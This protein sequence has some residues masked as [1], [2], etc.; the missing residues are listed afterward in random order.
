MR[1][2]AIGLF[3]SLVIR[4]LGAT[5]RIRTR[6]GENL[7][8]ARRMSSQLVFVFWHGR[9]L[10]M[11]YTHRN[12]GV[13]ILASEHPDG[14]MLG[15]TIRFLGF[16]HVR[17]SS[18]RGGARAI[19]AM[20]DRLRAGDDIGLT[21][22]GPRGPMHVVKPGAAE[23]AKLSGCA[24]IPVT[25]ASRR[26]RTFASWDRFELPLP[27]TRVVVRY[28][29]PVRVPSDASSA[30]LETARAEVERILNDITRAADNDVR[31]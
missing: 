19:L 11:A 25:S 28:G 29:T 5:W 4:V 26:H 18:T 20:V 9:L 6:G 15:R 23:I 3:G 8:A 1:L 21:V 12:E 31:G 16:G 10:P 24:I 14:E 13:H 17:G 30:A 22:D 2:V 27:F 7:D